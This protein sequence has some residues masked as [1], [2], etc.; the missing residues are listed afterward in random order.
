MCKML[1]L[2]YAISRRE[3]NFETEMKKEEVMKKIKL[4]FILI[5]A[6]A[7]ITALGC[8]T[9]ALAP[10]TTI[11]T[12]EDMQVQ[13]IEKVQEESEEKTPK[14]EPVRQDHVQAVVSAHQLATESGM[15]ILAA[16]GSAADA[17]IAVAAVLSVV[18]PYFSSVLG[19][20]TWALYFD[21]EKNEVTSL[22][23][24]GPVG[25]K[26]TVEDYTARAGQSGIHQSI[27]P[28][29]WDGWMLWLQEYGRLDLDEILA[30]AVRIARQGYPVNS[31]MA[32][33]LDMQAQFIRNRP[34]TAKIYMPE[35]A[36][37]REGD[38]VYQN[39]LANTF[40]ALVDAYMRMI[41]EGRSQA[42]QNAR[43]YYYRGP[44][45]E[46][47]VDFSDNNHGYLTLSDFNNF[48]AAIVEPISI[49]YNEE[50][51]VFENPPNS[52]GITMLLALNILKGFDFSQLGPNDADTIHLQVEAL[53]LAF[54][55]RYY[56]I[57]DPSLTD[58]P[59]TELLSDAYAS[60]QRERID[61]QTAMQWPI[62][63]ALQ[64]HT[65]LSNTTTFHIV[66]K[67]GN[68]AA[69]TT[70]LGAQFLVISNTGIHINNRMRMI[71][72]EEDNPNQLSAGY[73]VRHTSNPYMAL[74]NGRPYILG[75][76]TG[77]D[78]QPQGQLQQFMHVVEFALS[79]QEAVAMPRF[80]TTA[81]PA[82]TYPYDA[83]NVL[84]M[85][86]DFPAGLINGLRSRGHIIDIGGAFGSAN[87]IIIESDGADV[88][89]GAD[90][91]VDTSYGLIHQDANGK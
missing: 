84:R 32:R 57:G 40:E 69:V 59:V 72:L 8:G 34:D 38:T 45:A 1:S 30:P 21:A 19:G 35:G 10:V 74:K 28:G 24:V 82:G 9:S 17:A 7:S 44:L 42:I 85:E 37:L 4:L 67:Y 49:Q 50:I 77:V 71:S 27:V 90:P 25:S 52:Q 61:M 79:A 89:T 66:D 58:I 81:F 80:A 47:I 48:E 70:S 33:W 56:Y 68:G 22:D 83:E 26:A 88:Q 3:N 16:G 14:E 46:A 36:L 39:D 62:D 64:D 86:D 23:G 15:E 73:K 6:V 11:E 65:A 29:A 87:M 43:D 55:D 5:I 53:K 75:G 54:A 60:S 13:G 41:D 51:E 63:D 76:N 91:R 18:E 2:M 20:G 78:N 31:S 12:A